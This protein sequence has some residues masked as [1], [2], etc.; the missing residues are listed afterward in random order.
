MLLGPIGQADGA[1]G[2]PKPPGR[3]R[4]VRSGPSRMQKPE[5]AAHASRNPQGKSPTT[6]LKPF[7]VPTIR[8]LAAV[9]A[10]K[11]RHPRP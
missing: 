11:P 2:W 4:A 9:A 7:S 3:A 5:N 10:A 1:G 6:A 8:P